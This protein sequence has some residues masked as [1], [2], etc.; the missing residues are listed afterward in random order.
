MLEHYLPF[1]MVA[2][3]LINAWLIWIASD[4]RDQKNRMQTEI[5]LVGKQLAEFQIKVSQDYVR[6]TALRDLEDRLLAAIDR[7]ADRLDR[8]IDPKKTAY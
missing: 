8:V 2:L 7:I 4:M 5:D 3:G 1:G 6:A